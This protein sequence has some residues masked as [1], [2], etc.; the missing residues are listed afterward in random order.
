MQ[1]DVSWSAPQEIRTSVGCSGGSWP[2]IERRAR[3]GRL[4]VETTTGGTPAGCLRELANAL[5]IDV[6]WPWSI[7]AA[8]R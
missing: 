6:L 8:V 5:M 1:S 7:L 2:T 3:G 4:S